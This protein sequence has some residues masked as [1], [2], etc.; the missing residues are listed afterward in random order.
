VH[1]YSWALHW[2]T[3]LAIAALGATY[4][5]SQRR[6]PA[7]TTRRAAF[8]VALILLLAVYVTPLHTIALQYLLSIHFLQ[9]VVTAE[10]APGLV[11][12]AVAP[13]LGRRMAR[14]IHPLV[15]LPLWLATYFVW[16]IPVI[17]DA[18][19][20]RPHS[21]LHVEHLSYFVAGV[22][23]WW[24][25]VTGSY[26]DGVKAA[27]LFAAF[28][29]ASPLGLLLA[30]LPHPVYAFYTHAPQ[31]WGLSHATDQEIAGVSM[32]VEQAIVFF[33]VFAHFFARFLRTEQ[34]AG[35]F[36]GSSR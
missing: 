23:M 27:Y 19:L 32:A 6:W 10:W 13:A 17:Y 35:V 30:L 18:A 26:S 9:N 7:D 21:L 25:V 4:Y 20:N 16:H 3:L 11:V 5:W 29:L 15:V 8:D 24:P 36:S 22:L 33:A 34:I 1:P 2:D 14:Y 31:L 12:F 28:V